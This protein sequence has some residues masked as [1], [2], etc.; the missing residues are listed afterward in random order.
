M[1]GTPCAAAARAAAGLG[2]RVHDRQHADRRERQRRGQGAPQH[3]DGQVAFVHVPQHA[4]DDPAPLQ[5]R[6]VRPRRA[7]VARAARHIADRPGAEALLGELLQPGQ[8]G[9]QPGHRARHPVQIDLVL[10]VRPV[11][12]H[13]SV[14][15]LV[16]GCADDIARAGAGQE[17]R[18]GSRRT[19]RESGPVRAAGRT[20]ASGRCP[21]RPAPSARSSAARPRRASARRR[22]G[23]T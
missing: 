14:P 19:R 6:P 18:A 23:G 1:Y 16:V 11:L 4:R 12:R 7:A 8:V 21:S 15:P 3:L 17:G 2:V 13:P 20:S 10:E 22:R 9:G 5:R